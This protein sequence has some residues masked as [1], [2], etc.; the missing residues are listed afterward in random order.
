MSNTEILTLVSDGGG[1]VLHLGFGENFREKHQ[2]LVEKYTT[3]LASCGFEYDH[4]W[5]NDMAFH[6]T[7]VAKYKPG[8]CLAD[9]LQLS[10]TFNT[11]NIRFTI[12]PEPTWIFI[13][14]D[15]SGSYEVSGEKA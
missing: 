3:K 6:L 1:E 15:D 13:H 9:L 5:N 11:K 10:K 8:V 4:Y 12:G 7:V 14:L 2:K